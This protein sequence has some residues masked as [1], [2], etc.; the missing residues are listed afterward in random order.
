[1]IGSA[2][3]FAR[4]KSQSASTEL[5]SNRTLWKNCRHKN[6]KNMKNTGGKNTNRKLI[7]CV[8]WLSC[9]TLYRKFVTR[10]YTL[11]MKSP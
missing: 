4:V 5:V 11:V 8:P 1:M 6:K 2:G 7:S 3:H 9:L 10:Q